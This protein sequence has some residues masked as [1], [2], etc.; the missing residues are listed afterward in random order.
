MQSLYLWKKNPEKKIQL[1]LKSIPLLIAWP[2]YVYIIVVK[3]PL[4]VATSPN[5]LKKILRNTKE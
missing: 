3:V 5:F 4:E 1:F 2:S